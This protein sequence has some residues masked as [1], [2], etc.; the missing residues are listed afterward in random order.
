[1]IFKLQLLSFICS[2]FIFHD[3]I[4]QTSLNSSLTGFIASVNGKVIDAKNFDQIIKNNV[5]NGLED[6]EQLRSAVKEEL[7]TR[8]VML[9]EVLKLALDKT[10]DAIYGVNFVKDNFLIDFLLKNYD[11]KHPITDQMIKSEYDRQLSL[12]GDA[13]EAFQYFVRVIVT[14]SETDA[15]LVIS[16]LKKGSDFYQLAKSIS[17]DASKVNGGELGWVLPAQISPAL[18]TVMVN[19]KEGTFSA[20]PIQTQNGWYIIKVDEKRPFKIP[21][22]DESKTV[23]TQTLIQLQRQNYIKDLVKS[24]KIIK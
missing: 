11:S 15:R 4:A 16:D 9:Q 8:Q 24:A 12:I 13:S 17:L 5:A 1:M 18:A 2:F 6:N 21:T 19:L 10:P 20:L 22:L 23:L 3:A 14:Q 7:I